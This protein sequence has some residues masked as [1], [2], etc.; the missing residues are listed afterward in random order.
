MQLR[1]TTNL[2]GAQEVFLKAGLTNSELNPEN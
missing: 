2:T 1:E